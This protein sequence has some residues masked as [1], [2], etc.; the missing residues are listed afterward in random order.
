MS[1]W[2]SQTGHQTTQMCHQDAGSPSSAVGCVLI[3]IPLPVAGG[4]GGLVVSRVTAI[5]EMQ[6][7][8]LLESTDKRNGQ[9]TYAT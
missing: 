1:L 5:C 6:S 7:Q 8:S 4:Y 3:L 9:L 2:M